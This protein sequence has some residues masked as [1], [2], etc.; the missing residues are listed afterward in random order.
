M[1]K[2]L[3]F[4]QLLL[5]PVDQIWRVVFEYER[6]TFLRLLKCYFFENIIK[7]S[8]FIF[9]EY[10]LNNF[11]LMFETLAR[12]ILSIWIMLNRYQWGLP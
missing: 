2:S 7:Q 10:L 4:V 8:L 11:V 3:T 5:L 12:Q 9:N 1:K 6:D